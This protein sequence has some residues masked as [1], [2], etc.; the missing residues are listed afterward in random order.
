M[1]SR[2]WPRLLG[3]ALGFTGCLCGAVYLGTGETVAQEAAADQATARYRPGGLPP[4][5]AGRALAIRAPEIKDCVTLSGATPERGT[6]PLHRLLEVL[7]K[8]PTARSVMRRA[9][10]RRVHVCLD[11]ETDLLAYYFSG[12][13]VI[14]VSA[15]LPEGGR[16]AFLAHELGHVPQHPRYSDNRYFPAH[17]LVLLRR[18]RE[19]TAEAMA[20]RIAWELR[21][22][23]HPEAWDNKAAGPY[24]DVARAFA[25]AARR[26]PSPAGLQAA[27]RAAFDRWFAAR[28]RRNVY[29]RM[30]L[31]H[32][33][34]IAADE[35][36]L[37][38]PRR[39]LNQRFLVGIGALDDGNFLA[40]ANGPP[41][42][43]GYYAGRLSAQNATRLSRFLH[44]SGPSSGP[45]TERPISG[46]RPN[47]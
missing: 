39:Q 4:R 10:W 17:D 40:E 5:A 23:G 33:R 36:G 2:L 31:D 22:A 35:I 8:S 37:V 26:D 21:T 38:P 30:T 14:G 46:P 34:R 1:S 6:S 16:I 11:S 20:V 3:L 25:L 47:S 18:V 42:T 27:T 41:L 7:A 13:S 43:D 45:R 15:R 44:S 29:D 24:R 19:A 12:I 28:W 9:A 32:L